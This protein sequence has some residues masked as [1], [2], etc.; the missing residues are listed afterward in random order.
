MAWTTTT[1]NARRPSAALSS[2][3]KTPPLQLIVTED[4]L[5]SH[6][7]PIPV[8]QEYPL[9]SLRG[10]KAGDQA[11]V[12]EQVKAAEPAGRVTSDERDDPETGL[13]QRLRLV[14]DVPLHA[15][16]ADLRVHCL[17][18]WE[19]AQDQG[20]PLSWVTDLRVNTG[21]GYQR[22]RGGRARWRMDNETCNTLQ[23]QGDHCEHHVGQGDPQRSVVCAVLMLWALF[24]APVQ[25][26]CCPLFHAVWAKLGSTRRL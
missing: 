11:Y 4:S 13:R 6:A 18:C 7:P 22:M 5:R 1:V 16:N 26:M 24:V 25:P 23:N 14:S 9:H 10:V 17:A 20:Q 12:F 2:C 15:S 3:V 21:T 19:W 8:L